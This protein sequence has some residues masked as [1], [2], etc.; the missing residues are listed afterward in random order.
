MLDG[1]LTLNASVD[2]TGKATCV[3]PSYH[4]GLTQE[5][6]DCM[7]ARFASE[8]FDEAMPWSTAV[9]VAVRAGAVTQGERPPDV[10]LDS[11]ET[12]RM[13]DAFEV[14]ESL[15]PELEAC[16]KSVGNGPGLRSVLVGARVG[17]DGRAE[18]ALATTSGTMP[19]KVGDCAAGVLR[20][21]KYPPP[22]GGPGIVLV[23]ISLAR[24]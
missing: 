1:K 3:I 8:Q 15:V 9:S 10:G 7:S 4:T 19:M 5:V 12:F 6:E 24:R 21:A 17:L 13:A 18:C 22:K 20:G 23:P 2:A 11:I 16:M 14:L